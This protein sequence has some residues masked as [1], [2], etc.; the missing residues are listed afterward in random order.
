MTNKDIMTKGQ[1][2]VMNTYGRF[3]I[4][5]VKG[6]GSYVWDANGKQYLD[7][8]SG[9]AVCGL[10][11]CHPELVK[12]L[13]DQ[14]DTLWHVSNLYWIKPQVEA[15]EK[16]VQISGLGKAFFCN[17]G[18]EANEAAIKLARKYFYRRQESHKNHIIVFKESFHGRTLA[19]VTATGQSKYQE[20]FA[21]LPEGFV[22][23]EYNNLDSVKKMVTKNTCAIMLEPVQGEG[24]IHPADMDFLRGLRELCNKEELLLIFDEVQCGMGRTGKF[25]AFQS[26]GIKP[27]IVTMA[28]SLGGG[29]PI[30]AMLASIEVAGGFAP[31]DHASTFG[32][33]PLATA[34]A[35]KVIDLISDPDFLKQ[36]EES[37][38]YLQ[39][40]LSQITDER[41]VG[42][43]GRGLMV[44]MEFNIDVKELIGLCMEQGLLLLNAGPRVLRF[45]PP[46]NIS[47]N[48]INQG[49]AILKEALRE[50]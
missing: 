28:K 24:G 21:P 2:F 1:E 36:V 50:L 33:N 10:G 43:R 47:K 32:G 31:G 7:F 29:I 13:K 4:A 3:P 45:V 40:C 30:G 34:A 22:Y 5:P 9:I 39:E 15:A 37:G 35:C 48:E 20:G 11:H 17:S 25:F 44:G 16:L 6:R 19:T 42:I 23:A 46:L 27:D 49:V 26:Y 18:A 38:R 8:I 41:I 12:V 14:V